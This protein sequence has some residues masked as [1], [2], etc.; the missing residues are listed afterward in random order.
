ML[1]AVL[2]PRALGVHKAAFVSGFFLG[3]SLTKPLLL[4]I[5]EVGFT[6]LGS[7]PKPLYNRPTLVGTEGALGLGPAQEAML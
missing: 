5:P 6:V 1:A 4:F 7:I 2:L 3:A